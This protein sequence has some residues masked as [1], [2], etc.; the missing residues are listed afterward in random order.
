M[1][2]KTRNII[3]TVAVV[4]VLGAV[5]LK[6][7]KAPKGGNNG[8]GDN[9]DG[10]GGGNSGG[11]GNRGGGGTTSGLDYRSLA[12]QIFEACDGYGTDE[13]E[14]ALVF[15][16]L[17]NNADFDALYD[18]YGVREV[19]SGRGNIF[20]SN[21]VGDLSATLRDELSSYYIDNINKSLSSK[22]ITRQI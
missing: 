11:G 3:I 22:G 4:A 6:L 5:A 17:K 10:S 9:G 2:N 21:F 8:D 1:D 16:K 18:A 20:Q 13:V 15:N 19:S 12:N 14:I 7:V